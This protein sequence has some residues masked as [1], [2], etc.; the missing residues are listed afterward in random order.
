ML[1]LPFHAL[2]DPLRL[3]DWL[4]LYALTSPDHNSSR[5]DLESALRTAALAELSHSEAIEQKILE[6]LDELEQ[7]V[8]AARQAYPFDLDDRGVLRLRSKTWE[9]YPAYTF[10]LCLSYFHVNGSSSPTR[11]FEQVSCVAAKG[12]LGGDAIRF[13]SPRTELPSAFPAAVTEMCNRIG[14]GL[15][16]R[17]Q[18]S[19]R[20]QDDGLDLV[21]WKDFI[22]ERPSKIL[23]F[24]Q[25]ASGRNW[26]DKLG[27]L[28]P[29]AFCGQWLMEQPISPIPVKSFFIPHR[30]ERRKWAWVARNA[31][32]LFDRCRIAF[33]AHQEGASY[34]SCIS[35]T[36]KQLARVVV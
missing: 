34:D 1:E 7:R 5:G 24:G 12:Y 25:C 29:K 11:L 28:Q 30:V 15:G 8:S 20:R 2:T 14:E 18:S 31:G 6:V 32:I 10:C 17:E 3:A 4:E 19:L 36:R 21:A 23:L 33:W 26:E 27:D 9:D 22:D 13:G 16:F 35:W